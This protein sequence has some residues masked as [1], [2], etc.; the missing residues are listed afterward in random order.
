LRWRFVT[1]LCLVYWGGPLARVDAG[2][3]RRRG[4]SAVF[5]R[6]ALGLAAVTVALVLLIARAAP[7]A[8]GLPRFGPARNF[9]LT[10]QQNDRLWLSQLR[11]RLV[12]LTFTCTTC[13]TCPGLLPGLLAVERGLGDAAGRRVVFLAIT[14]DPGRDTVETLRRFARE[15][16]LDPAA[17]VLLTGTTAE[18][19]A[20]AR[21]YGADVR[22]KQGRVTHGC[23][24]VLI[25]HAGEIRG[26][27][28][29]GAPGRLR[30][31]VQALLAEAG[32]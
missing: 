20:V 11:G 6:G 10:T 16:G 4:A 13:E 32:P 26:R 14:V 18:L 3:R 7:A 19:A 21:W 23:T 12:V 30:A 22:R 8:A 17:W 29:A 1:A 15:R 31:D 24:A 5:A 2:G 28:L 27:Y 9:A 25:D